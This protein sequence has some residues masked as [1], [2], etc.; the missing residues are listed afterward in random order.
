[1]ISEVSDGVAQQLNL[2]F[3]G[4]GGK[5][6]AGRLPNENRP[7][8]ERS[9]LTVKRISLRPAGDYRLPGVTAIVAACVKRLTTLLNALVG[10]STSGNVG[11]VTAKEVITTGKD[12]AARQRDCGAI[13][14]ERRPRNLRSAS[15]DVDTGR[16]AKEG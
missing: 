1:M 15:A 12:R 4:R 3:E 5:T 16:V 10:Q 14:R 8:A 9:S 7:R 11:C 6:V 2:I 13:A